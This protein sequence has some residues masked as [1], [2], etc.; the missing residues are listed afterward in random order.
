MENT[1]NNNTE[2]TPLGKVLRGIVEK[3]KVNQEL[4]AL[5]N[6]L[7]DL[8]NKGNT[9]A[10]FKDLRKYVPSIV[11][12]GGLDAV[13]NWAAKNELEIFGQIN[14]DNGAWEYTIRWE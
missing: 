9:S 3:V 7:I 13:N 2:F 8:A 5:G 11:K 10:Q 12:S 6:T 4:E 14:K 1:M